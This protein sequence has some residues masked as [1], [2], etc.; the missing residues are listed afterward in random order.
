MIPIRLFFIFFLFFAVSCNTSKVVSFNNPDFETKRYNSYKLL[1]GKQDSISDYSYVQLHAQIAEG[2]HREMELREFKEK[3]RKSELVL[4]YS[5]YS[6][7]ETSVINN[8]N[9][10][11]LAR[12]PFPSNRP[13]GPNF[14][15]I[16]IKNINESILLIEMYD[17]Q[18]KKLVWQA[19]KELN[20]A[21]YKKK[22][23]VEIIPLA[24]SDIFLSYK[25]NIQ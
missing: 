15:N 7:N 22:K 3:E 17:R 23:L 5:F 10:N 24:I 20:I 19:S 12:R 11:S 6:S 21:A 4:R 13:F 9:F 16:T 25:K 2:I 18:T 14:N 1:L 8:N